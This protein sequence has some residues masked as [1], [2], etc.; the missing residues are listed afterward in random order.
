MVQFSLNQLRFDKIRL[1]RRF[2]KVELNVKIFHFNQA[3]LRI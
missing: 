3:Q 2:V 1:I